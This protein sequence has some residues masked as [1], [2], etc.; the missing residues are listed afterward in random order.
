MQGKAEQGIWPTKT[1]LGYRNI[2]GPDGASSPLS[3]IEKRCDYA[4]GDAI[5]SQSAGPE[6]A[7]HRTSHGHGDIDVNDTG[8][9]PGTGVAGG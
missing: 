8:S 4:R 5:N 7:N 9:S 2:T 3:L 6:L 1:P